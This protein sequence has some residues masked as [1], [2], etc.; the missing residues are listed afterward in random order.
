VTHHDAGTGV[1]DEVQLCVNLAIGAAGRPYGPDECND[2]TGRVLKLVIESDR[3]SEYVI[4]C[5]SDE[6]GHLP[7]HL[8]SD[9]SDASGTGTHPVR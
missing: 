8:E 5:M 6:R 3:A 1:S 7:R 4:K 9:R 2:R